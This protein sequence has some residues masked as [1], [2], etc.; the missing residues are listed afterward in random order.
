MIKEVIVVEGKDDVTA[1]K[2]AVD[3]EVITTHGFGFGKKL[4][5]TL[6]ELQNR[7]GIIIFTDPDHTGEKIRRDIERAVPGAKHAYLPRKKGEKDGN[8]G[9]EN[10]KPEDI[11]EAISRA[12]PLREEYEEIYDNRD[13]VRLGLTGSKESSMLREKLGEALG[14]GHANAKIFL[15]RLNSFKIK[16]EELLEKL[17]EVRKNG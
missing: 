8:I 17:E 14:I 11:R 10:A 9:V 12:K 13:L 4:L 6:K 16:E 7:R 15:K 3:A 5:N 2:A 1:V